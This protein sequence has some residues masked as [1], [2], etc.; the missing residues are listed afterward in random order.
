MK[1]SEAKI[2]LALKNLKWKKVLN[3]SL[4]KARKRIPTTQVLPLSDEFNLESI[5]T[6]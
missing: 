6:E 3:H 2:N 5:V 1:L 4:R